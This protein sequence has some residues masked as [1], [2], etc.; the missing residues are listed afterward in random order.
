MK[1]WLVIPG[2]GG[3]GLS[4]VH[5]SVV[6]R[7]RAEILF[8]TWSF[9]TYENRIAKTTWTFRVSEVYLV[10]PER[11]IQAEVVELDT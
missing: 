6:P 3:L 10:K 8:A 11:R 1:Y 7:R 4:L 9:C 5:R 2:V